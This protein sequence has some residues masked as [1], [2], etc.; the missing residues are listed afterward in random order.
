L[1]LLD[2]DKLPE[3]TLLVKERWSSRT[4]IVF[5]IFHDQYDPSTAHVPGQNDLPVTLIFLSKKG[6]EESA[7]V[8]IAP[9]QIEDKV[10]NDVRDIHDATRL[11]SRPPFSVD[12]MNGNV[13][14]YPNPRT[15][16]A[17]SAPG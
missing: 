3:P 11:G 13:P 17:R 5:D 8:G 15:T 4:Y 7:S 6:K 10:N 1:V 12:H 14:C 9:R 2:A 16:P